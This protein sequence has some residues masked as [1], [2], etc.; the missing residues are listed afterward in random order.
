M[1]NVD[2]FVEHVFRQVLQD[3]IF[4]ALQFIIATDEIQ[5][6]HRED[7]LAVLGHQTEEFRLQ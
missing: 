1:G 5:D 2:H 7:N 3:H 4:L 6:K